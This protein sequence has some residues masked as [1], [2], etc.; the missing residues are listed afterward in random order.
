MHP[1][2]QEKRAMTRSSLTDTTYSHSQYIYISKEYNNSLSVLAHGI[3]KNCYGIFLC[4][5]G[6]CRILLE[7]KS[8]EIHAGDLCIYLPNLF[9]KILT[10]SEDLRGIIC[11]VGQEEIK[12]LR[13]SMRNAESILT[14]KNSPCV[15]LNER[16]FLFLEQM[17]NAIIELRTCPLSESCNRHSKPSTFHNQ[18]ILSLIDAVGFEIFDILHSCRPVTPHKQD[19]KEIIFQK[20]LLSLFSHCTSKREVAFYAAEQYLTP[21]YFS[22]VIK[23]CSKKSAQQW[24]V[25]VVVKKMED[26]LSGSEMSIKE[27]AYA[28]NFPTQSFFGKYFKQYTGMSPKEYRRKNPNGNIGF[29]PIHKE[30]EEKTFT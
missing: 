19:R 27:I 11:C 17:V 12:H 6:E 23:A 5:E 24:I 4:Q 18:M 2:I 21:R 16:Q 15:S 28:F 26:L 8:Y 1:Y 14:I 25:E 9:L 3:Y 22:S 20:F 7:N 30:T 13:M 10:K 29:P